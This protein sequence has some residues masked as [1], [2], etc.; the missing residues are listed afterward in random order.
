MK[1]LFEARFYICGI[2]CALLILKHV[3]VVSGLWLDFIFVAASFAVLYLIYFTM[4]VIKLVNELFALIED[5]KVIIGMI[6]V[7]SGID[8]DQAIKNAEIEVK[9]NEHLRN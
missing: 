5:L 1:R 2:L 3:G 6:I 9:V 7:E 4:N 8:I